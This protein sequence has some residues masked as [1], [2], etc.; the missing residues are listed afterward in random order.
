MRH[1]ITDVPFIT[2]LSTDTRIMLGLG[3]SAL[4]RLQMQVRERE[5]ESAPLVST[6]RPVALAIDAMGS[7]NELA[8][9]DTGGKVCHCANYG[10]AVSL[11]SSNCS[12]I[13]PFEG[14]EGAL[15]MSVH[16]SLGA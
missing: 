11:S 9:A 7:G 13:V 3:Y 15:C 5:K 12:S 1:D 8:D 16:I 14:G 6:D 4:P 2:R 10:V